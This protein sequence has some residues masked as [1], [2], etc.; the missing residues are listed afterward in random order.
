MDGA[1]IKINNN[2]FILPG[3]KEVSFIS[4]CRV[5][6]K[7]KQKKLLNNLDFG[8]IWLSTVL[9]ITQLFD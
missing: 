7:L 6:K 9:S 2:I 5:K 1:A 4:L 8:C 3:E